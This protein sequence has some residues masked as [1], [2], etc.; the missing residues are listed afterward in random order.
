MHCSVLA[1]LQGLTDDSPEICV[2]LSNLFQKVQDNLTFDKSVTGSICAK[3]LFEFL[4]SF[5]ENIPSVFYV[6]IYLSID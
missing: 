5:I 1:V 3:Q 2:C 4:K 6:Y